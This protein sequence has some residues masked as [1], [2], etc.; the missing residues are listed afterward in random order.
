MHRTLFQARI[1]QANRKVLQGWPQSMEATKEGLTKIK[2]PILK[3][4]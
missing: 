3:G 1:E 4:N 2:D